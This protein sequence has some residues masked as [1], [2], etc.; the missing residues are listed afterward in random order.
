[1]GL[2]N[3]NRGPG[4]II[5][6]IE[7]LSFFILYTFGLSRSLSA[8][9]DTITVALTIF[10]MTQ[11]SFGS[12][13]K[14][15]KRIIIISLILVFVSSILNLDTFGIGGVMTIV[16]FWIYAFLV[17]EIYIGKRQEVLILMLFLLQL[18]LLPFVDKSSYNPNTVALVYLTLGVYITLFFE[19][20]TRIL[21]I[22]NLVLIVF[23]EYLIWLTESRTCLLAF[24]VYFVLRY[25]SSFILKNKYILLSICILLTVGSFVYVRAY[26]GMW[27]AGDYPLVFNLLALDDPDKGFFSGRE[28]IWNDCLELLDKSP[29]FGTGSKVKIQS[30]DSANFH[31][32]ILNCFVVYGYIVGILVIYMLIRVIMEIKD[33]MFDPKIRNCTIAFFVF[34]IVGY[35]ETNLLVMSF[36]TF[37]CLMVAYSRKKEIDLKT[38]KIDN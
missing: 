37:L 23:I 21:Q 16:R 36:M 28:L 25:F 15:K 14:W 22:F 13:A 30:F 4:E 34:L 12:E 26:V 6:I 35:S 32:S 8:V 3:K 24:L 17:G 5:V 33:Y 20:R 2:S 19:P 10:L 11:M 31:N 18:T 27:K 7:I 9:F 38:C 1:M 29:W